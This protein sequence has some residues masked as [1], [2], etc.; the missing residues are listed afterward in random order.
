MSATRPAPSVLYA[1]PFDRTGYAVAARRYLRAL[2]GAGM[3]PAWC[4]LRNTSWGYAPTPDLHTAPA[5]QRALPSEAPVDAPLIAH[6]VPTS[7]RQL[8]QLLPERRFIG[9][10]VWESDP[11]PSRWLRDLAPAEQ[12]WVPTE[13]NAEVLRRSGISVPIHVVPH[14]TE[15]PQPEG[16]DLPI[17][18]V[19]GVFNFLLV[20]TW[21]RRKRPDLAIHAYLR[22]FTEDD[23]VV[24][25]V[26]T[27][28][29]VQAWRTDNALQRETWWQVMD[30]VRRYPRP[31]RVVLINDH[32]NDRQMAALVARADCYVSLTAAEGWG[33]GAFDAAVRGIPLII[34]G[35]GGQMEWLGNDHPGAVPFDLVA[36][37]HPDRMLF[38]DGMQWALADIDAAAAMM[39]ATFEG[40]SPII[41]AAPALGQRLRHDYAPERIGQ[42]MRRLLA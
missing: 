7:W 21:D 39:R 4:G 1:S 11:I 12:I 29:L 23:P 17:D 25:L 8:R 34:T 13:W 36:A 40:S 20:S 38:E 9:Q 16:E 33:L 32:H 27:E 31:A 22:A 2:R 37:D 6:C 30:V 35:H 18:E 42:L 15:D 24:L 3:L 28:Q 26:K 5:E 10:T 41:D 14:P 19:P